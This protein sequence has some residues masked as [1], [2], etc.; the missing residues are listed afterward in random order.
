MCKPLLCSVCWVL[1]AMASTCVVKAAPVD[2][3]GY[4][5]ALASLEGIVERNNGVP[6]LLGIAASH[7]PYDM[8][9]QRRNSGTPDSVL[10]G[11]LQLQ[12]ETQKQRIAELSRTIAV[13]NKRQL[14]KSSTPEALMK[15]RES[16]DVASNL[17]VG[18]RGEV[19]PLQKKIAS[20]SQNE[21]D[22]VE[23]I[24]R[25]T[26]QLKAAQVLSTG[27]R[28]RIYAQGASQ[29]SLENEVEQVRSALNNSQHKLVTLQQEQIV[30]QK[31]HSEAVKQKDIALHKKDQE[32]LTQ[33]IALK[34]M[35]SALTK[36]TARIKP[37]EIVAVR[38]YAVGTALAKDML[39]LLAER[40][41]DGGKVDR[42][43]VLAGV[44]DTFTGDVQVPAKTLAAALSASEREMM[45][46]Q[47]KRKVESEKA[48]DAYMADF[49]KRK[50]VK[51][52]PGGFLYQIGFAG[53]DAIADTDT[54]TIAVKESLI[55][56]KLINDMDASGVL[57]SQ[58]LNAYPELFQS[59]IRLLKSQG[60]VTLVVPPSLAYGDRGY[61]PQVPPGATIVYILRIHDVV[62][63]RGGEV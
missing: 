38:D 28:D 23:R 8:A 39:A 48:G 43:L 9:S 4:P 14:Q 36:A 24:S 30:A 59:A 11:R 46:N 49:A 7:S 60:S 10:V 58:P 37:Q 50:G 42:A 40:E 13:L 19:E 41:L 52:H 20:T 26:A 1:L 31:A 15:L 29:R 6:P 2:K 51:K 53:N 45:L 35:Q 18:L 54:V 22:V 55:D 17:V 21:I 63:P 62:K 3:E 57:V 12:V 25:L 56:G 61:P 34:E 32:L 33:N 44:R 27:Q 5:Q 47:T 16:R